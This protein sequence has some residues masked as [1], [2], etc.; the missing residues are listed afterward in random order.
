MSDARMTKHITPMRF[1][2][3]LWLAVAALS[4]ALSFGAI[5]TQSTVDPDDALRLVQVRDL[6]HGQGWW[7][8]SQHR[9]NPAAGGGLMHWSRIVDAPLALGIAAFSPLLGQAMAES[10]AMALWPLLLLAPLFWVVTRTGAALGDRP[11]AMLAPLL[12]ASNQLILFQFA[13]LRIDHHGWQ[14]AL[15]GV[16]LLLTI[17]PASRRTGMLSGLAAAT[18]LAISLEAL[19]GVTMIAAI[20]AVEWWWSGGAAARARLIAYLVTLCVAALALQWVTRGPVGLSATWCDAL[21]LPYLAA[22]GAA[23]LVVGFGAPL[24]DRAA[25]G[26]LAR[27]V[28]LGAGGLLSAASLLLI[29]PSCAGGPFGTL[30]PIVTQYWYVHVREGLPLWSIIDAMTGYML[31]PTLVGLIGT[32]LAMRSATGEM[33]RQWLIVLAALAAMALLSLMVMRVTAIAHLYAIPGTAF[34]AFYVW[35]WARGIANAGLRIL[36]TMGILVVLPPTAGALAALAITALPGATPALVADDAAGHGCVDPPSLSALN[37]IEPTLLFAP[38]DVGPHIL[39]RTRHS[40]MATAHHRN[41]AVMARV[42]TA[43]VGDASAARQAIESS[44]AA[45]VVVCTS[46]A[47]FDNFRAAPGDSLADQLMAGRA[48]AW[49]ERVPM[50]A[51]AGL[52]VWRI[53]RQ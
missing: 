30:D 45:L 3:L 52:T 16:L 35:R 38:L 43:F 36:A 22:L 5:M 13:P 39:Q 49:L 32:T 53:R 42:I 44:G 21:S 18:Y 12:L 14:I 31:A 8:I 1:A 34:A 7:D 25:P 41:N 15:S 50:P 6:L 28:C 23:A 47:E 26:R 37:A 46:A 48:P 33:R 51:G 2:M 10:L 9:I 17:L 4:I 27:A 19:P 40:V 29:A 20:M 24:V 11:I